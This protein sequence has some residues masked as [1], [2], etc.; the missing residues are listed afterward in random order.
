MFLDSNF[1]IYPESFA[2]D[3]GFI[4]SLADGRCFMFQWQAFSWDVNNMIDIKIL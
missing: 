2:Y 3:I 4:F 1:K